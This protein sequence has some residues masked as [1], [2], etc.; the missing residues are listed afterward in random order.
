M[1]SL[2]CLILQWWCIS[3][4]VYFLFLFLII[5]NFIYILFNTLKFAS[6][7]CI[8]SRL[9]CLNSLIII[10]LINPFL[11]LTISRRRIFSFP[12]FCM[13][14][15]FQ[16]FIALQRFLPLIIPSPCLS[17]FLRLASLSLPLSCSCRCIWQS[18]NLAASSAKWFNF[19]ICIFP[20]LCPALLCQPSFIYFSPSLY[21]SF[22]SLSLS[23]SLSPRVVI[24]SRV[25]F[26]LQHSPNIF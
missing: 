10:S 19:R 13:L 26:P 4:S 21:Y 2:L 22:L 9:H 11:W 23:L 6:S 12:L 14:Q 7:K 8:L 25:G 18:H 17:P 20:P 24:H 5:F 3:L 1:S 16:F 15:V